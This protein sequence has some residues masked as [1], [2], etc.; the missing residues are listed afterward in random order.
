MLRDTFD[1]VAEL[2]DRAR[3]RYPRG[4]V[5]DLA[6]AAGLGPG[7]RV[8][9]I[10]PGTGQL[11]VPLAA[12]G[13]ALTAVEL[14]P[15]LAAVARRNLRTFPLAE[16]TVADFEH[17]PLPAEPFDLVVCATAFHWLDPAVRL[18]RMARAL[19]PGGLLALITTHHVKGG[20]VDFF[21]RVQRCYEMW[22]PATPPDLRQVDE[23]DTATDIR[24]LENSEYFDRVTVRRHARDIAY[25]VDEYID[26]L[27]TYSGHRALDAPSR[28]GLLADIRDLVETRYG[29][30][31]TK[32][33]LH[34]LITAT[35]VP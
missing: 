31:L 22:D 4:L 27:L 12:L 21:E 17:W 20:T 25:S 18:P 7:S 30:R 33:Y 32:R 5:D 16:V 13:C 26:V 9:E 34:E 24:E 8:L 2:Y 29:G 10:A 6:R 15:S 1:E 19:R 35:R 14:G 28:A 3:P 11:T 23:A